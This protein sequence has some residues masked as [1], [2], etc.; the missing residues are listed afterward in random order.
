[1]P[2]KLRQVFIVTL[3]V[4]LVILWVRESAGESARSTPRSNQ[5]G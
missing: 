3:V 4:R 5:D 1:V 2:P